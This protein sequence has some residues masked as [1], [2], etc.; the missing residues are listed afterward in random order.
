MY[1]KLLGSESDE[2]EQVEIVRRPR[3]FRKRI[4][5]R[6]QSFFEFNERFRLSSVKMEVLSNIIGHRLQHE[7]QRNY[8]LNIQQQMQI[9]LHWFGTGCQYHSV[10]EMPLCIG[11]LSALR[12]R[13]IV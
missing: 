10:G 2:D 4:H 7:M 8:A 1:F 13:L 5:F 3:V 6:F 11:A 9:A 12:C